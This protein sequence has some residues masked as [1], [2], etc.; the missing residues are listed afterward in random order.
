MKMTFQVESPITEVGWEQTAR[1][2]FCDLLNKLHQSQGYTYSIRNMCERR[3][4]LR[5][6]RLTPLTG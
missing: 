1:R 2:G 3:S 6:P 5:H 4:G